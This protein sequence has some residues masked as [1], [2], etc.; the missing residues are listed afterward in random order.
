MASSAAGETSS[1]GEWS[2]VRRGFAVW[3]ADGRRG[4]VAEIRLGRGGGVEFSVVTGLFFRTHVTVRADEIEVI[5]PELRRI[6]VGRG[7]GAGNET[8]VDGDVE[9]PGAISTLS[10]QQ[11]SSTRSPRDPA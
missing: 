1:P 5:L 11:A 6:I 9:T 4:S 7:P 8:G 10:T 3:L 2:P